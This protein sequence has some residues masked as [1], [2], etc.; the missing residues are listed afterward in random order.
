MS[1]KKVSSTV[2]NIVAMVE[3][4][5]WDRA[6]ICFEP[7]ENHGCDSAEYSGDED[8]E[9]QYCAVFISYSDVDLKCLIGS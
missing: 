8:F 6:D 1:N 2:G 3:F 9:G 4:G 5:E 7:P